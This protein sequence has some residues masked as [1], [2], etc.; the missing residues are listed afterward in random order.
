MYYISVFEGKLNFCPKMKKN[1]RSGFVTFFTRKNY[2][3]SGTQTNCFRMKKISTHIFV[4]ISNLSKL[5]CC[6]GV[7]KKMS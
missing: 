4:G 6:A 1:N 7:K 5:D 3:L 2:F